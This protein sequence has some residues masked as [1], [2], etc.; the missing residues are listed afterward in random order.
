MS[1]AMILN[2]EDIKAVAS[3]F[4]MKSDE[5]KRLVAGLIV[6]YPAAASAAMIAGQ[7]AIE[8]AMTDVDK[9]FILKCVARKKVLIEGG[10]KP[11]DAAIF[12][13]V[14]EAEAK[15]LLFGCAQYSVWSNGTLYVK[16]GGFRQWF[17]LRKDCSHLEVNPGVPEWR[18]LKD[19]SMWVIPGKASVAVAGEVVGI[20]CVVGINGNSSDIIANIEAKATRALLKRLWSKVS[21]IELDDSEDQILKERG[22][23]KEVKATRIE[24]AQK[25]V[26]RVKRFDPAAVVEP[27][28]KLEPETFTVVTV[29]KDE[30]DAMTSQH[31]L[32]G[33]AVIESLDESDKN[34]KYGDLWDAIEKSKTVTNLKAEG[35]AIK[36]A[37]DQFTDTELEPLRQWY[38]FRMNQITGRI[39]VA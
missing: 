24:G 3:G 15:Q 4:L 35:K 7:F 16:E 26:E 17:R 27:E 28:K 23:V 36:E 39:R 18:V 8:D 31:K 29:S 33:I 2:T 14:A 1:T 22:S 30:M 5:V 32:A 21:S 34:K 38:T 9:A 11:R 6:E 19:K 25:T 10:N 20:D 37:G 13:V 12:S